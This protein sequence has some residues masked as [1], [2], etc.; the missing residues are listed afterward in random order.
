MGMCWVVAVMGG[1][2]GYVLH[3]VDVLECVRE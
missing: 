2:D 1:S 3:E